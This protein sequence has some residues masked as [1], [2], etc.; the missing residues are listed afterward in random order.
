LLPPDEEVSLFEVEEEE[1]PRP[2]MPSLPLGKRLGGFAEVE[3]GFGEEVSVEEAK[4][5]L[6]CDLEERE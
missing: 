2:Q 4:R 6:K 3:L 1:K 5:C